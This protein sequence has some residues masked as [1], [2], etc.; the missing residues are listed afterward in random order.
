MCIAARLDKLNPPLVSPDPLLVSTLS[1][2]LLA[3][4]TESYLT[5][6][7]YIAVC[8]QRDRERRE[9]ERRERGRERGMEREREGREGWREGRRGMEKERGKE[10]SGGGVQ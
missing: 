4:L 2:E 6:S 8:D 7:V 9:G 5:N 1:D 10:G 3:L